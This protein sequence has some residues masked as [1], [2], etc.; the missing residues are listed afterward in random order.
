M[1]L[2]NLDLNLLVALNALLEERSATRA[3]RR[4]HVTQPAISHALRRLRKHFDDELLV[5]AGRQMMLTPLA[6]SLRE[7]IREAL[8]QLDALLHDAP[9]FDLAQTERTIEI[10][11]S[12][13][14]A[15]VVVTPLLRRLQHEAPQVRVNVVTSDESAQERFE[16]GEIDLMLL[17]LPLAQAG[18]PHVELLRDSF[19]FA[20][21]EEHPLVGD[22]LLR[23][24]L[25]KLRYI[26]PGV[27][28]V[29]G[30][31]SP[32]R[33]LLEA[34]VPERPAVSMPSFSLMLEA[35]VG[36]DYVALVPRQLAED[37]A[38]RL[39][40]RVV[41]CPV[42]LPQLIAVA[43]W[44]RCRDRDPLLKRLRELMIQKRPVASTAPDASHRSRRRRSRV[45]PALDP[46][47]S[48]E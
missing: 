1:R 21:W 34:G 37:F 42:R 38:R 30:T 27:V 9:E 43:Q 46:A 14:L 18:H 39:P 8:V 31:R 24:D 41:P 12:D 47:D 23:R 4:V 19:V 44:H 28:A 20:V 32:F 29:Q 45:T 48:P 15:S 33:A 40:L 13:H 3:A 35:V 16:S 6:A 22:L 5:R 7:P 25:R 17:P 26:V 11:T 2:Y 36:T 10:A